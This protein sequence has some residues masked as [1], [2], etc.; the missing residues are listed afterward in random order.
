MIDDLQVRGYAPSTQKEYVWRVV[1]LAQ[2]FGWPPDRLGSEEIGDFH[3]VY[4]TLIDI[5]SAAKW[6]AQVR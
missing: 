6:M 5:M 2:H 1:R 3:V 4:C